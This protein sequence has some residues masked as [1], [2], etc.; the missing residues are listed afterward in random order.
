MRLLGRQKEADLHQELKVHVLALGILALVLL[1][2]TAGLKFDRL[3]KTDDSLG[4]ERKR[5]PCCLP[6]F[7]FGPLLL[8]S[9]QSQHT[10]ITGIRVTEVRRPDCC[11]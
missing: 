10:G 3:L 9:H 6:R 1:D 8:V 11:R 7:K 5:L 4:A 2:T